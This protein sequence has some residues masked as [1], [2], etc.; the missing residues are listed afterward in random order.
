MIRTSREIT[1]SKLTRFQSS[2]V[3][4]VSYNDRQCVR[5]NGIDQYV[6]GSNAGN[7][8]RNQ[9]FSISGWIRA[10][11]WGCLF[12]K[13][14]WGVPPYDGFHF[15]VNP[16]G[17]LWLILRGGSPVTGFEAVSTGHPVLLD[18]AWH[19]VAVTYDGSSLAQGV[20]F[21]IDGAEVSKIIGANFLSQSILNVGESRIGFILFADYWKAHIRQVSLW[22]KELTPTEVTQLKSGNISADLRGLS[23]FP[24]C[25]AWWSLGRVPHDRLDFPKIIGWDSAKKDASAINMTPLDIVPIDAPLL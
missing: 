24:D 22:N 11:V 19:H 5:L 10:N 6:S 1:D 13:Y 3:A 20:R 23:F 9:P 7:W 16:P 2:E 15:V 8:E 14:P 17:Y 12:A 18:G 4:G 21:F 25:E